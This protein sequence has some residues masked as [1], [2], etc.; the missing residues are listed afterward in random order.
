VRILQITGEYPPM[1]GGVG[2]FTRELSKA[3]AVAG[4]EPHV[5][6]RFV[7]GLPARETIHGVTTHR[8]VTSWGWDTRQRVEAF[9]RV[10]PMDAINI[11]YQAAAYQMHPAINV[12]PGALARRIPTYVTFHDLRVPYLFPKAGPLRWKAILTMA[13]GA[14]GA[15]V[16]NA[17]DLS[18]L[19]REGG[20]STRLIPIGSNV[21]PASLDGFEREAW[22][23]AHGLDP[24][25]RWIGYFGFMNES[26]GGETLLRALAE[27][28]ARGY[29]IG[30]LHIGGQ[31]GASDPTN[32]A[33]AAKLAALTS[34][35][36]LGDAVHLT[37]FLDDRGV[38]HAFAACDALALPYVDGAS[39]RRGT[40][41]AAI[42]HGCA[43]VTTTPTVPVPV[44][45]EGEA[46]LFVPPSD[47]HALAD[48]LERILRDPALRTRLQHGA[49]RIA[50]EFGW[51]GIAAETA[52]WL[53]VKPG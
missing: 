12:L 3:L 34:E 29:V 46:M 51:H 44:F 47:P 18:T 21:T 26:K 22:L 13:R 30:L 20:V 15:V 1:Q 48:G 10:Y 16:T 49:L 11:Q 41:M 17:E 25:R 39:F 42:A 37:G 45:V 38:T 8:V 52:R 53:A 35:L 32:A 40:L 28:N 5:L 27:L 36:R 6:T 33:Y 50:P 4:H 14:S 23:R 24:A 19:V 7:E 2:D 43:I 31:T 9:L